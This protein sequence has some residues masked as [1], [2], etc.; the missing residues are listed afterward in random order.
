MTKIE[1]THRP[2]TKGETWNP[3]VGCSLASPGC[4]NCYAMSQ[5][6]RIERMMGAR[7]THYA[8][9]TQASKAGPVWTG[10]VALAPDHIL[11]APLK[12]TKPRTYFVNSM[13]DVFHE[14]VPDAWI[15]RVFAIMALCPQHTFLV[16]T[17]RAARMRAYMVQGDDEHGDYFERLADAAVA[18]SGSPCAAHVDSVNWPLPNVW[19]G[20]ST[21]DQRRADERIPDLLAT[22]AAIRFVSAEPL[23][24]PIDFDA[25]WYKH[26]PGFFG[27]ALRWHHR[28]QC[29]V[30]EGLRYPAL[31]WVIVGG[32]SGPNARPMQADWVH[33]IIVQSQWSGVPVFIK[34]LGAKYSDE[35]NGIAGAA[36]SVPSEASGLIYRRLRHRSGADKDEWPIMLQLQDWPL[37]QNAEHGK[38]SP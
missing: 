35:R 27:S 25:V 10:K 6:A 23:L 13:G 32:E 20:V 22:P 4:T 15:D 31:D 1:W 24:G 37:P 21:E 34:Q 2:G 8:G 17:K 7:G 9:M 26:A 28:G 38:T 29:H 16:L 3:I 33:N 30:N 5:A 12:A 11:A 14:D 18:L 36:L 19:L